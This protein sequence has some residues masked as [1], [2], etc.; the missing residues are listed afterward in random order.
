MISHPSL[1]GMQ[2]CMKTP[3]AQY[4]ASKPASSYKKMY[5]HLTE[6]ADIAV[7]VRQ[8]GLAISEASACPPYSYMLSHLCW[9]LMLTLSLL[10]Q[11][12]SLSS[13]ARQCSECKKLALYGLALKYILFSAAGAKG[14]AALP[15]RQPQHQP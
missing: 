7:E 1:C 10:K 6:Q 5:A 8:Q 3:A 13:G 11:C 12:H 14:A 4:I 9:H 15:G 2:I